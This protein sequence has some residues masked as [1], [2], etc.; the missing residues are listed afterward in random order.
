[1]TEFVLAKVTLSTV[2]ML[3]TLCKLCFSLVS[4][5]KKGTMFLTG[6]LSTLGEEGTCF[7]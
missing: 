7:S 3:P 1:M 4:C 2:L 6:L 5:T